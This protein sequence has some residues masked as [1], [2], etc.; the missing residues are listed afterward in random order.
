MK[1]DKWQIFFNHGNDFFHLD[2]HLSLKTRPFG[3]CE[4]CGIILPGM[5]VNISAVDI[6]KGEIDTCVCSFRD[7][8]VRLF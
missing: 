3:P 5:L 7:D 4:K 6:Q 2:I 8:G 1:N